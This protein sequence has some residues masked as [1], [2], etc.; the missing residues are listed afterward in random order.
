MRKYNYDVM[1]NV[2]DQKKT[3]TIQLLKLLK[4][5]FELNQILQFFEER[6]RRKDLVEYVPESPI[7]IVAGVDPTKRSLRRNKMVANH[8]IPCPICKKSMANKGMLTM[9]LRRG[10]KISM[11][12]I[13]K[14]GWVVK[15]S[16]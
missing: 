15:K 14:N 12:D 8:D 11:E 10:H 7:Y 5:N 1:L 9:H 2:A 4:E 6:E 16:K 3:D 13:K